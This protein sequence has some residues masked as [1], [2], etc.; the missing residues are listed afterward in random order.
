[1]STEQI[2]PAAPVPDSEPAAETPKR[3]RGKRAGLVSAVAIILVYFASVIGYFWLDSTAAVVEPRDLQNSQ[4]T[5][6]LLELEELR[7]VD[8]SVEAAVTVI[9]DRTLMDQFG[10]L[11]EDMTIRLYP[12]NDFGEISYPRG[13]TPGRENVSMFTFGDADH[14]PF[15]RF[16]TGTISADVFVGTGAARRYVSSRVEIAG[17]L[18]GWD[19][20]VER[21]AV[22]G[23]G[24]HADDNATVTFK[25]SSGPLALVAGFVLVLLAL[26][27]IALYVAIELLLGRKAFQPAF[28]TFFAAM[29]FSV[30]PIR[31]VLPGNPPAGSWIDE[32]VTVWVLIALTLATVLYIVAWARRAD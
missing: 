6:V 2:S 4:E 21:H 23:Y 13:H 1:M 20:Y 9:P 22:T 17:S 31:N 18:N 5:V 32:A 28:S 7:P 12:S 26:P 16:T 29:L 19:I 27:A 24:D 14:W 25:R 30:V 8:N 10:M 11:S 15:D 3:T